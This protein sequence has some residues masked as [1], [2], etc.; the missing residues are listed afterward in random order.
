[1]KKGVIA[2]PFLISSL[3]YLIL[4][5]ALTNFS[6]A[7]I[8]LRAMKL[9]III[10]AGKETAISTW[11]LSA[12]GAICLLTTIRATYHNKIIMILTRHKRA[13]R[14]RRLKRKIVHTLKEVANSMRMKRGHGMKDKAFDS[15]IAHKLNTR[16][17][18]N[19]SAVT[20][21]SCIDIAKMPN[22]TAINKKTD[23]LRCIIL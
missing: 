16:Y 5:A 14:M 6:S 12:S 8:A 22:I 7:R 4:S 21:A 11:K 17:I 23:C 1:M 18:A 15:P 2:L 3:L 10:T 13:C 19:P 20:V 9:R